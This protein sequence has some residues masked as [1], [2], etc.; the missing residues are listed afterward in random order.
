MKQP[1]SKKVISEQ[2]VITASYQEGEETVSPTVSVAE[3][4]DLQTV[5]VKGDYNEGQS[6]NTAEPDHYEYLDLTGFDRDE[7]PTN[8][9]TNDDFRSNVN[10]NSLLDNLGDVAHTAM[11][12]RD[13]EDV[14][15]STPISKE[16]VVGLTTPMVTVSGFPPLDSASPTSEPLQGDHSIDQTLQSPSKRR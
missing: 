12:R 14:L 15:D 10:L 11:E 5:Q 1:L 6:K 2:D 16:Q 9:G 7:N 13:T 3:E 8:F 4:H